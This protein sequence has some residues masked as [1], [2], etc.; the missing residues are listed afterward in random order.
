M[1]TKLLFLSSLFFTV[2][3]MKAQ[4]TLPHYEAFDYA[5]GSTLITAT[6]NAGFGGWTIPSFQSAGSTSDPLLVASPSWTLPSAF[7]V[8]AGNALE[9]VGG[10]DDP[11]LEM[12]N[13]GA[14]GTIYSSFVFRVTEQAAV[15]LNNTTPSYFFSFAKVATNLTSLNY[16]SCVYIVKTG[17]DTFKLGISENNNINNVVYTTTPLSVNTDIV[18]VISYDIDNAVSSMWINPAA[19]GV[20][21]TTTFVT[22]ETATSTRTDLS[23]IRLNLDSNAKTPTIVLDELRIGNSWLDVVPSTLSVASNTLEKVSIYPNPAKNTLQINAGNASI[24]AVT[25]TSLEG[26]QVLKT[27]NTN[28]VDVSS[29][30]AGIYLVKVSGE[31]FETI[32]KIIIE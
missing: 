16:T 15:T 20:Q 23:M 27:A 14:T 9:F 3:G 28:Q 19:D 6:T 24:N 18:V 7:P 31:N 32:K 17:D 25:I 1:K 11:I 26:K 13:Q 2:C 8:A 10:G 12:T 21:P 30:A 29:L 4:V 5:I 22:D